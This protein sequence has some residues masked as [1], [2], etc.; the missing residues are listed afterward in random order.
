MSLP[1]ASIVAGPSVPTS[2]VPTECHIENHIKLLEIL[3]QMAASTEERS[4]DGIP[5]VDGS[6]LSPNRPCSPHGI[7][8]SRQEED[9][10]EARRPFKSIDITTF[11][12]ELRTK[13]ILS[14]VIDLATSRSACIS[15]A[16][17]R[18][19]RPTRLIVGIPDIAFIFAIC[20][21]SNAVEVRIIHILND[22]YLAD[23]VFSHT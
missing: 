5:H 14:A 3:I 23:V 7:L 22:V 15:M 21:K 6:G 18:V 20:V 2:A 10:D 9:L 19:Q 8:V 16:L 17:R 4:A 1:T 12:I 11:R 13:R